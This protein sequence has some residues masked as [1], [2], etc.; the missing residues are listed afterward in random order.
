MK[1]MFNFLGGGLADRGAA[2]KTRLP[3]KGPFATTPFQHKVLLQTEL[4]CKDKPLVRRPF[5]KPLTKGDIPHMEAH[6]SK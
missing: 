4:D 3:Q 2:T 1:A 6:P 5:T